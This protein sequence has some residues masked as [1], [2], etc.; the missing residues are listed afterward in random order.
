MASLGGYPRLLLEEDLTERDLF[1]IKH[2]GWFSAVVETLPGHRYVLNFYDAARLQQEIV[3]A[4]VEQ[5]APCFAE[6]GL[7]VIVQVP[8]CKLA[9]DL[10]VL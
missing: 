7:V 2:K 1:E 9:G 10:S 6:P 4:I 3:D 5:H 8:F